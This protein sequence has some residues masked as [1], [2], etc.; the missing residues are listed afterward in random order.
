MWPIYCPRSCLTDQSC[1]AEAFN[2]PKDLSD[3]KSYVH[4][5]VIEAVLTYFS[6][7]VVDP[8]QKVYQT[9][10]APIYFQHPGNTSSVA[11]SLSANVAH[12]G[13]SLTIIGLEVRKSGNMNLLVLDP[14]FKTPPGIARLTNTKFHAGHPDKLLK[15]Y[16]RGNHYLSKYNSFEIMKYAEAASWT[17]M[18]L[19]IC[20]L[21]APTPPTL[22]NPATHPFGLLPPDIRLDYRGRRSRWPFFDVRALYDYYD[23]RWLIILSSERGVS[24]YTG[25]FSSLLCDMASWT[26]LQMHA[27]MHNYLPGCRFYALAALEHQEMEAT[28]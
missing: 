15:A 26:L 8:A 27:C 17:G 14:M 2:K 5:Q 23:R 18:L 10:L 19:I 22:Q 6:A 7:G 3:T 20:R 28:V 21:T 24:C 25:K 13:H 16:R 11:L 9:N 1:E 12:L 4:D